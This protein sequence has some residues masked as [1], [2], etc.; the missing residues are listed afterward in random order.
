MHIFGMDSNKNHKIQVTLDMGNGKRVRALHNLDKQS[1]VG[2]TYEDGGL[3]PT[4][5][6]QA[7]VEAAR[8]TC[9]DVGVSM[10]TEPSREHP[11]GFQDIAPRKSAKEFWKARG[12]KILA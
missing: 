7:L 8:K 10:Y 6:Y 2:L 3:I 5:D 4:S 12:Y 1:V 9:G 11:H